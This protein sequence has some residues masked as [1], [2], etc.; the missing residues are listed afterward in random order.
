MPNKC[1]LAISIALCSMVFTMPILAQQN[2]LVEGRIAGEN[3]ARAQTNTQLWFFAGFCLGGI[4][5]FAVA[6]LHEP[7]P[8]STELLGKSPEYVAGYTE[9]YTKVAKSMQLKSTLTGAVGCIVSVA[10]IYVLLIAMV[11]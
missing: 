9:A 8:P 10:A 4:I 3:A 1:F 6:Y 11:I 7:Y 2:D 5:P